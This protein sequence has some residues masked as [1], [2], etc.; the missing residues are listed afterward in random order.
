[1]ERSSSPHR[2]SLPSS[3][4]PSQVRKGLGA[5]RGAFMHARTT[6]FMIILSFLGRVDLPFAML[7]KRRRRPA[8]LR[9]SLVPPIVQVC[10]LVARAGTFA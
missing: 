6:A 3:N 4:N 1:M 9:R 7:R 8:L 2:P 10:V 5:N